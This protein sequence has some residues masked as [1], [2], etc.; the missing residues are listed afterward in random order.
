MDKSQP[1]RMRSDKSLDRSLRR[2]GIPIGIDDDISNS[3]VVKLT[4]DVVRPIAPRLDRLSTR[5]PKDFAR[6][7]RKHHAR[8]LGTSRDPRASG[9]EL[10][11]CSPLCFRAA[12]G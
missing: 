10:G 8:A 5:L 7:T 1:I 11:M 12:G 9:V 6:V 3:V 2:I 4:H